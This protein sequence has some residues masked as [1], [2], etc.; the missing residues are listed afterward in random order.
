M[1]A[2]THQLLKFYQAFDLLIVDEVDAF[3]YVDN[4]VLYHAVEQAVKNEGTTIFLTATSTDELDKKVQKGILKRLS[5]PR[6]FHGNP[7]IIPQKVWL[8]DLNKDLKK[9]KLPAKLVKYL[10]KQRKT[11]FPL[12]IFASE[13]KKGQEIREVLQKYFPEETVGFVAST[14]ENRLE[15]V[16]ALRDKKISILV[17]TTILERGVTFPCV[18]VIVLEANHRLFTRSALVQIGGRVG[19][20]MERPTGDLLFFHDGTNIQIEKAINEIK[21]MNREAGL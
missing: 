20:S 4:P 11:K 7:L 19:R 6:R 1:I 2:T 12:L 16:Q 3:P 17:T 21:A 9:A 15:I 14:T 8:S 10:R 18:D 5:L 13:I